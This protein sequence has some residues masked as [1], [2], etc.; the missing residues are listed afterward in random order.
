MKK[1]IKANT[2]SAI[3]TAI[4][5]LVTVF[6]KEAGGIHALAAGITGT[7]CGGIGNF[8]ICRHWVFKEANLTLMQQGRRYLLFWTGNMLLNLG[9][10]YL[11][12]QVAGLNYI[13]AKIITSITIA[14]VYTYPVQK[15]YVFKN[16]KG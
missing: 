4:D 16:N 1:F 5:Y 8:L 15:R 12:I 10:L 13:V 3:A 2:A 11:L 14:A 9:G 6:L 7:V